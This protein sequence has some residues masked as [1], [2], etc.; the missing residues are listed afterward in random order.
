MTSF[1]NTVPQRTAR[2]HIGQYNNYLEIKKAMTGFAIEVW[3]V[4]S[5]TYSRV[6]VRTERAAVIRIREGYGLLGSSP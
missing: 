2:V 4:S 6:G 3:K 1:F 5:L